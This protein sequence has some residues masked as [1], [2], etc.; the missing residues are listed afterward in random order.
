[1]KFSIRDLL[2]LTVVVALAATWWLDH[3]RQAAES[4]KMNEV[5]EFY[6]RDLLQTRS[7]GFATPPGR[8]IPGTIITKGK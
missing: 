3:R 2:W 8:V 6:E 7:S 5:V 1:M 4:R